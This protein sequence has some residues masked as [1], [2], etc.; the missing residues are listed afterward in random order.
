MNIIKAVNKDS[1]L[2]GYLTL[3]FVEK[4]RNSAM[5]YNLKWV[6]NIE[7]AQHFFD[8]E[9]RGLAKFLTHRNIEIINVEG[10]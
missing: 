2:V 3:V 5:P 9:V 6:R 4:R 7:E 10:V 1:S 8:F